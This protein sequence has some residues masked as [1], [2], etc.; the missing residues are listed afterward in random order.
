MAISEATTATPRVK[1]IQRSA[2]AMLA[3][4]FISAS[5]FLLYVTSTCAWALD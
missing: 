1:S 3:I 4:A 2:L 5:L